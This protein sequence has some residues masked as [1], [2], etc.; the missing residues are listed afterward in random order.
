MK[1]QRAHFE[2][3]IEKFLKNKDNLNLEGLVKAG[4]QVNPYHFLFSYDG[5]CTKRI[6]ESIGDIFEKNIT[7]SLE[8]PRRRKRPN[9]SKIRLGFYSEFILSNH[10]ISY[11]YKQLFLRLDKSK[12]EPICFSLAKN[13]D[14]MSST[15]EEYK[16]SGIEVKLLPEDNL[17]VARDTIFVENLDILYYID[18][19]MSTSSF[20]LAANR[21]AP[22]QFTG[23]GHPDTTG[24]RTID[25]YISYKGFEPVDAQKNY[26]ESLLVFNNLCTVMNSFSKKAFSIERPRRSEFSLPESCSLYACFQALFKI[27]PDFDSVLQR[28]IELDKHAKLIFFR[29]PSKLME[30]Q[31]KKRWSKF[32]PELLRHVLFFDLMPF[33]QYLMFS[34]LMDV[35]LD[36][37]HFGMGTTAHQILDLRKPIITLPGKFARG[38]MVSGF[39]QKLGL[40]NPPVVK[41][42]GDYAEMAVTWANEKNLSLDFSNQLES[43]QLESEDEKIASLKEFEGFLIS[44]YENSTDKIHSNYR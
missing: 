16:A 1:S 4:S 26:S 28:I 24:L 29:T 18:I 22:I 41:K 40:L 44:A 14:Q 35:H 5:L 39:Y 15:I 31:L 3:K 30:I 2:H 34:R 37:I 12:F 43:N 27:H 11:C 23:P 33:D 21:L 8:L 7:N 6:H 32:Y 9:D 38:R 13:V 25:Y 36:P 20:F 17:L 19:G 42:I 10:S